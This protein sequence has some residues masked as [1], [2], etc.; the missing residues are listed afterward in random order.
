MIA[1]FPAFVELAEAFLSEMPDLTESEFKLLC[2][3]TCGQAAYC[4]PSFDDFD[5]GNDPIYSDAWEPARSVRANLIP[6]LC[7]DPAAAAR[8]APGGIVIHAARIEGDLDLKSVIV[9]F[10]LVLLKCRISRCVNLSLAQIEVLVL[11]GSVISGIVADHISVRSSVALDSGF[12][13][14]GEVR[15]AGGSIGGTLNCSG[16]RFSTVDTKRALQA[17]MPYGPVLV[18]NGLRVSGSI[19]LSDGFCAEGIVVLAGAEVGRSLECDDSH[20]MNPGGRALFADGLKVIGGVFFRRAK[21]AGEVRLLGA[22]IAELQCT[23]ARFANLGCYTLN[24]DGINI[25]GAAQ[26]NDGF[27][28][29][30]VSFVGAAIAGTLGCVRSRF[31][32][33]DRKSLNCDH[34]RVGA[35]VLLRG[36]TALGQV[37][38]MDGKIGGSLECQRGNFLNEKGHAIEACRI[39]VAGDGF[40]LTDSKRLASYI[41]EVQK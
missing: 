22:K 36:S 18:A 8:V 25:E 1:W 14:E 12:R 35:S 20:F 38:L 26:L 10:P 11:S 17:Q 29:G 4:G 30:E 24:A 32:N 6:I 13:T 37:R 41:C 40:L 33:P 2:A 31:F 3:V 28:Q 21:I 16:G 34:I 23:R 39:N 7:V 5:S 9:T 27:Y 19:S 15:L